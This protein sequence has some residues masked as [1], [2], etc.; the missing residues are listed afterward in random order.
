MLDSI[1]SIPPNRQ[2]GRS[3]IRAESGSGMATEPLGDRETRIE[4]R[5][6]DPEERRRAASEDVRPEDCLKRGGGSE[7][8]DPVAKETRSREQALIHAIGVRDE[9]ACRALIR[10]HHA[11]MV[12]VARG[13]VRSRAVAEEV[14]QETWVAMLQ[15]LAEFQGRS[16]LKTWL[17]GILIRRARAAGV[18]ERRTAALSQLRRTSKDEECDPMDAFFHPEDHPDAGGWALPPQRW[19]HNPE[20]A[21]LASELQRTVSRAVRDLP[22]AQ[23]VVV[24]LRDREGWET[25]EIAALLGRTPNWVRVNLHR[26]RLKIRL[27][28]AA[29]LGAEESR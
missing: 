26:A 28:L 7:T 1:P 20:D 17:F 11:E 5:S 2:R 23:Q 12:R 21:A 25:G 22:E 15:G 29:R 4:S 10:R 24:R 8:E 14:V 18:R 3:S 6:A 13:F 27:A 19:R 9:E 16:S